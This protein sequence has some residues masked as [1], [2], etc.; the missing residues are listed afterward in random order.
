MVKNKRGFN[1]RLSG[2]P[3]IPVNDPTFRSE[4]PL[5]ENYYRNNPSSGW[6]T[7]VDPLLILTIVFILALGLTYVFL[8][9]GTSS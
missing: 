3:T 1:P 8:P 9:A 4:S 6:V 2:D 7:R 5:A